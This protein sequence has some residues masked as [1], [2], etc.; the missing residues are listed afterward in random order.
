MDITWLIIQLDVWVKPIE[1]MIQTLFVY[2]H[3]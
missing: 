2:I 3:P 1:T